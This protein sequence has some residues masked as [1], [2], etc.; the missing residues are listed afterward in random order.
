MNNLTKIACL[1][2]GLAFFHPGIAAKTHQDHDSIKQAA[3][4]EIEKLNEH[5]L[6]QMK[7]TVKRLDKRLKLALCQSP[8]EGFLAPGSRRFGKTTV[9]VRCNDKKTWT[10]Y[11]TVFADLYK[12][13]VVAKSTIARGTLITN[14]DLEI[15]ERNV[16]TLRNGYFES[17][18]EIIGNQA[19]RNIMQGKTLTKLQIIAPKIVHKGERVAIIAKSGQFSVRMIGK[20]LSD[21]ALGKKIRIQ[22]ISSKRIIE[23][24]VTSQGVVKV[25]F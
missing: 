1:I 9:G 24:V 15:T 19:K 7:I 8:L 5:Q 16:S 20:A 6:K 14:A 2:F 17:F 23:A 3:R 11:L 10:I 4:D 22:N 13:I 21:G 18:K 25:I 12:S